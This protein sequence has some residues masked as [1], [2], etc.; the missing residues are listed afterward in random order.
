MNLK[1]KLIF[2]LILINNKINKFLVVS[3]LYLK[4]AIVLINLNK[5]L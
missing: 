5:L 2:I 1:I 4:I 3:L